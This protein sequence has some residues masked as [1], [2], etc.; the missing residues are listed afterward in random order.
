M[1]LKLSSVKHHREYIVCL[2]L[3]G[4]LLPS[5]RGLAQTPQPS[6]PTY[7]VQ[8]GDSLWDIAL[9]FGV[10]LQDLEAANGI[11]DANAIAAGASL[12]IPGL[13][14]I[15]G[16]LTTVSVP[17][18]ETLRSLSRRY[19]LPESTIIRLNHL[20]S[21]GAV[22][23]GATLILPETNAQAAVVRRAAL[24]PGQSLLELAAAEGV[25][26][27]TIIAGSRLAGR[28][29]ALPGDVLQFPSGSSPDG[30]E[31]NSP[32]A[33]P[34]AIQQVSLAPLP[35][36]QGKVL[37][38]RVQ[39]Q[40]GMS[41]TGSIAGYTLHFFPAENGEWIAMQ[42]IHALAEPGMVP[43]TL[44]GSLADGTPFAFSQPVFLRAG[45]YPFDPVLIVSPETI[46]PAVTRPED[47][48]WMALAA[49]ATPLKQWN[50]MFGSPAAAPFNDC[51]PSFYGSRRS[52]NGGPYNFFHTG[53]D[54]CGGVGSPILAAAAGTVVFAGPLTVRGN[55]TMIDHGWGVYTG[56]MHQSEILVKVGDKVE[57]GQEIGKVG[58]TGRVTGPHLHWEIF[59]G[60]VQVDPM[61]WL[62]QAFP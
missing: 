38:L 7:V 25:N 39:G 57:A 46:D 58:G 22:Y 5:G 4:L 60:G 13:E 45:D 43:L 19:N 14:G 26:P 36:V 16:V 37:T 17:F 8:A 15:Q 56:Y 42:G 20:T 41:L 18:G 44:S 54:F 48:E 40:S 34:G 2:L 21:P 62:E 35:L 10:T 32:G 27:W 24:A 9:R 33:L 30:S 11:T 1:T 49:P 52:Y 29:A 55:A 59:V 50:G 3:L 28:W 61:D 47:A 12:V 23:A 51:W 53:L 31:A 6:G